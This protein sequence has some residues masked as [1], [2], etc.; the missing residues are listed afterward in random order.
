MAVLQAYIDRQA[1]GTPHKH[2][3]YVN[4]SHASI[5][6]PAYVSDILAKAFYMVLR[7]GHYVF[8]QASCRDLVRKCRQYNVKYRN[9]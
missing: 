6:V 2:I 4:T 1:T 7:A 3:R 5:D 8:R 9:E